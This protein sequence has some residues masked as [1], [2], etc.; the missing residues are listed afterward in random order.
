MKALN[1]LTNLLTLS[2]FEKLSALF[3]FLKA[4][5]DPQCLMLSFVLSVIFFVNIFGLLFNQNMNYNREVPNVPMK[6]S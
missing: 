6:S 4:R 2:P 5:I 3:S 1:S